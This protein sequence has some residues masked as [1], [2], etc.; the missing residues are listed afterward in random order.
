M[1]ITL[2]RQLEKVKIVDENKRYWFIRTF[3]GEAFNFYLDEEYVGL[4]LNNV[5]LKYIREAKI[6]DD[7]TFNI[8]YNFINKNTDYQKGEATKWAKQLIDFTNNVRI[9]DTVIM[10]SKSSDMLAFGIVTS[11]IYI[12]ENPGKI[13]H[14]GELLILP[15]KRRSVKWNKV[16]R[17]ED[18][19]GE[20][21]SLLSSHQGIT[22]ADDYAYIIEG[23]QESIFINKEHIYLVLN[24]G[25][26][27]EINAF[28]LQRFLSGLTYFYKEFCIDN[29]LGDNEELSIKIKLQS[30]GKAYLKA[31]KY[32]GV[33][34]LAL[35]IML[36]NN[37][38]VEFEMDNIK[39]KAGSDGGLKSV[40][41]FLD[42]KQERELKLIKFKDSID[43]LK[44]K[45]SVN[46]DILIKESANK[47]QTKGKKKNR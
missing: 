27:E 24:V 22:N 25:T 16:I 39:F 14:N 9:G 13:T 32:A 11:E 8:L 21:R 34:G 15:E 17:R 38:H 18:L 3:A 12:K 6:D 42:K 41:E 20:L 47:P 7:P 26:N 4:G 44:A 31:A 19:K 37:P 30:E 23:A 35:V 46:E 5:P 43:K 45:E 28:E 36:C 33:L 2:E 29:G 1:Q 40:T 10:P